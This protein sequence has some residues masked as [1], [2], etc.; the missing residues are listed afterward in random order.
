MNRESFQCSVFLMVSPHTLSK[1]KSVIIFV[2]ILKQII[3]NSYVIE[4][5][6]TK[7]WHLFQS[8]HTLLLFISIIFSRWYSCISLAYHSRVDVNMTIAVCLICNALCMAILPVMH[9]YSHMLFLVLL[10]GVF[11]GS[12]D[13]LSNV[14]LIETFGKEVHNY[15]SLSHDI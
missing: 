1:W 13:T 5:G 2:E 7:L 6:T 10:Y 9:K 15:S 3:K 14:T 8:D 4:W 11:L 12:P